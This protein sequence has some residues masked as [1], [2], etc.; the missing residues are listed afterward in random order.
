MKTQHIYRF[1]LC[2]NTLIIVPDDIFTERKERLFLVVSKHLKHNWLSLDVVNKGFSNFNSNLPK[3][4]QKWCFSAW[5]IKSSLCRIC[6]VVPYILHMVEAK[7]RTTACVFQGFSREGLIMAV[8]ETEIKI[9]NCNNL[10]IKLWKIC[11]N[12]WKSWE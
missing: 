4:Q 3:K 12:D 6:A 7:R 2:L 8:D 9:T 11:N 10:Q 1:C 5:P